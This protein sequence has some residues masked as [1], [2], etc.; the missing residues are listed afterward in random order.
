MLWVQSKLRLT[1]A[2]LAGALL[3]GLVGAAPAMAK[4]ALIVKSTVAEYQVGSKVSEK[5]EITLRAG[6]VVSVL[7][8]R[9][10]RT[11][12][13]PGTF[14]VGANPK[15]NRTRYANLTRKGAALKT[16]TGGRCGTRGT[17]V[18]A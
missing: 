2:G 7:T 18:P 4:D 11:M 6:D 14:I 9:G 5:D 15:S 12:R 17:G 1:R 3:S 13:G 8:R 10:T 16:R